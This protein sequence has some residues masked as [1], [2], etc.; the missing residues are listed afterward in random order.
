MY[1]ASI[2]SASM[3]LRTVKQ[4]PHGAQNVRRAR[5]CCGA[6][7]KVEALNYLS[8]YFHSHLFPLQYTVTGIC[9]ELDE[10][11]RNFGN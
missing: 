1:S 5:E 7:V 6:K 8:T 4:I 3:L 2:S 10:R 11:N 9:Q